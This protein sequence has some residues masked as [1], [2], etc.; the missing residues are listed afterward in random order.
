MKMLVWLVV[1]LIIMQA[2]AFPQ[3]NGETTPATFPI[4]EIPV[5]PNTA[6]RLSQGLLISSTA[7]DYASGWS[8][9]SRGYQERNLFLSNQPGRQVLLM[10]LSTAGILYFVRL[11][12]VPQKW[13]RLSLLL[14]ASSAHLWA[15]QHNLRLK[16]N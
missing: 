1:Y 3:Q 8:A 9:S 10:G 6:V 13:L 16:R 15:A 14:G 11:K 4:Q 2:T 12:Y 5:I 7:L